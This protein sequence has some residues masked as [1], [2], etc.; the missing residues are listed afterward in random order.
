MKIIL[1][2][3][4]EKLKSAPLDWPDN[5]SPTVYL[6][7]DLP[8]YSAIGKG[9]FHDYELEPTSSTPKQCI[10]EWTGYYEILPDNTHAKIYVLV[11]I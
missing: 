4:G 10:F 3:F 6:A 9:K 11:G 7:L 8:K 1:K 2:A 5:A